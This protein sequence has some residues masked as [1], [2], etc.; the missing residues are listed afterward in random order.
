MCA[1]CLGLG[2]IVA[3]SDSEHGE[4]RC[5]PGITRLPGI[6]SLVGGVHVWS[7]GGHAEV[8]IQSKPREWCESNEISENIWHKNICRASSSPPDCGLCLV[9]QTTLVR[10]FSGLDSTCQHQLS[11]EVTITMIVWSRSN[12][13][14]RLSIP[15]CWQSNLHLS[16]AD[17]SIR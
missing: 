14:F 17:Q 1:G 4:E 13:Y 6:W 9:I 15:E 16:S 12:Y 10:Y 7:G 8:N 11:S 5:C 3:N 2:D